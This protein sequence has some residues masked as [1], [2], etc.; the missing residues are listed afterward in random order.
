MQRGGVMKKVRVY[1]SAGGWLYE[2]GIAA[3]AIVIG[4]CETREAAEAEAA[5]V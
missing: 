4:R 5:L 2:V 1:E 3:R